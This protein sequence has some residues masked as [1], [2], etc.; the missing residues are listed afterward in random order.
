VSKS[1]N[2]KKDAAIR[3]SLMGDAFADNLDNTVYRRA[4]FHG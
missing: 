1:E 2:Y 4:P 3:R